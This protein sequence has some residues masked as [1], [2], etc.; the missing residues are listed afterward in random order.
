MLVV[1]LHHCAPRRPR[2]RAAAD[3]RRLGDGLMELP[4]GQ[5]YMCA[6]ASDHDCQSDQCMHSLH[7]RS[8]DEHLLVFSDAQLMDK[9]D[10]RVSAN[11]RSPADR[12]DEKK[13]L[14]APACPQ[15]KQ[16]EPWHGKT[17]DL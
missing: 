8:H 5:G 7:R 4:Y 13:R 14:Y 10:D 6:E 3:G 17:E 16:N 1:Q 2:A 9:E 12:A 15:T 11:D